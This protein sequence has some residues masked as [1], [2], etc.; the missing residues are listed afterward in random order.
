MPKISVVTPCYNEEGNVRLLNEQVRKVFETLPSYEWEHIFADNCS[1]DGTLTILKQMASED[2]RVKVIANLRN[3]GVEKS[4]FNALLA[5]RGD[6]AIIVAAD[7][8]D[9]PELIHDF[10]TQWELG[11]KV[12][13]GVRERRSESFLLTGIRKL[14]YRLL[15]L[16]ADNELINDA[17][18]FVLVDQQ[19]IQVLKQIKDNLPYLRGLLTS[20]GFPYTGI[21]Y[22]MRS[23]HSGKTS[24]NFFKLFLY[25]LNGFIS[26]TMLPLR[27]ATLIGIFMSA[28]S[29]LVAC[30][31]LVLKFMYWSSPP[32]GVPTIIVGMFLLFGVQ[33][34]LIGYLGE[35]IGAI[36]AQGRGIPRVIE[37]ERINF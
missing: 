20:L 34:F 9:P 12:V 24:N 7:L 23:R 5:A 31:Q 15:K 21:K 11:H 36:Y 10:V 30:V 18:D 19:V 32:P 25:A 8:Q 2:N 27:L 1:Q 4:V 6:A 16:T 17:G 28:L 26:N 3:F 33:F 37:R 14:Y 29:M 35:M 22:H 13:F